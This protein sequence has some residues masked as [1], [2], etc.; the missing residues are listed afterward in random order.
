MPMPTRRRDAATKGRPVTMKDLHLMSAGIEQ[1][2]GM[3]DA[4]VQELEFRLRALEP[5]TAG[6]RFDANGKVIADDVP[7]T[8]AP[9]APENRGGFVMPTGVDAGEFC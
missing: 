7:M 3:F 4:K 1:V 8:T 9:T 2:F 6:A 5:K